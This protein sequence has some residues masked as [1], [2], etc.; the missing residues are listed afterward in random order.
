M[1]CE[2]GPVGDRGATEGVWG[3]YNAKV[4]REIRRALDEMGW[5]EAFQKMLA[6]GEAM[7]AIGDPP[8]PEKEQEPQTT[9]QDIQCRRVK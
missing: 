7:N 9:N 8:A 2:A 6:I 5:A 3:E 1:C 4:D